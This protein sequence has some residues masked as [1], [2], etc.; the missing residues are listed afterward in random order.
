MMSA[1]AIAILAFRLIKD[2]PEVLETASIPKGVFR[3]V[4][5]IKPIWQTGTGCFQ[6]LYMVM[7]G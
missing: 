1:R 5:M 6:Y 2:Y 7:K 3:E 4:L